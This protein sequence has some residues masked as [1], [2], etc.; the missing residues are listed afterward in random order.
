MTNRKYGRFFVISLAVCV[1]AA[2]IVLG[3]VLSRKEGDVT[4]EAD[5]ILG[6]YAFDQCLYMN[7]LS[8][9]FPYKAMPYVY[10]VGRDALI[11]ADTS[12]SDVQSLSAQYEKTSVPADAFSSESDLI[13][14]RPPD[15]SQYKERLLR[16]VFSGGGPRYGLYQMDG[17]I[18]LVD[19]HGGRLWSIYRLQRTDKVTLDDLERALA[20]Q[21]NAKSLPQLTLKDVYALARRGDNLTLRDFRKFDVRAVGSG[22]TS[23]RYNIKGGCVLIVHSDTPDSKPNAFRLS[24]LGYD[25]YD[26]NLTVDIREG[27]AAVA[28]YLDPLHSLTSLKI[29]DPHDGSLPPELI[30]EFDGYRYYLNTTRANSIFITF[31]NGERL[32]L[33]QALE[34]RRTIIEDLVAN[35]LYNVSMMPVDSPLGGEFSVLHHRHTFA[36]DSEAFYPSASFMFIALT[37]PTFEGIAKTYFNAA[38]LADILSL[39]GRDALAG[40]LKQILETDNLPVI[41]GKAYISDAGLAAAGI[42]VDVGW[43]LSSHTPVNF[44]A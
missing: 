30:Y 42:T 20:V 1:I 23:L 16:A 11:I 4:G 25:P 37:P 34:E 33:K 22:F 39:Q 29:E 18:W 6:C 2:G 9:F 8:S 7:P 38:E 24:K 17:D 40:K 35:G 32:P 43:A 36:F 3:L 5:D 26:E 21:D 14:F 31:E 10:G 12:T 19:G 15:L 41:A 28:A 13:V 44:S 27:A